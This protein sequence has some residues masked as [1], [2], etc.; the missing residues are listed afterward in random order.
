MSGKQAFTA[1]LEPA[2]RT[3]RGGAA[4]CVVHVERAG[5]ATVAAAGGSAPDLWWQ[6]ILLT[7]VPSRY[8]SSQCL[9]LIPTLL[10][11]SL[12]C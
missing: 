7:H 5:D 3:G 10:L 9:A 11:S 1:G 2:A 4:G 6:A 8:V 12:F